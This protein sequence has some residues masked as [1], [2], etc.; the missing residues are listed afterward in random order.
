[1]ILD[2]ERTLQESGS[3]WFAGFL[4]QYCDPSYHHDLH[5]RAQIVILEIIAQKE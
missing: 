4:H 5:C 2:T 3:P 1:M